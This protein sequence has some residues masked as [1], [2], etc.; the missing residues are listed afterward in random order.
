MSNAEDILAEAGALK[1]N[2]HYV[3]SSGRHGSAYIDKKA[4]INNPAFLSKLAFEIARRFTMDDIG[5]VIGP[6]TGGAIMS[7]HVAHHLSR[8]TCLSV[9]YAT[10]RKTLKGGIELEGD[11]LRK[12]HHRRALIVDDILTTGE[13]LRKTIKASTQIGCHIVGACV[14]VNRGGV[15][16]SRIEGDTG[17]KNLY[18]DALVSMNLES[19]LAEDCALCAQGVPINTDLGHGTAPK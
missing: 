1:T 19:W 18:L 7:A 16:A 5:V 10:A 3:Y 9:N 15:T 8:L 17:V 6:E 12:A 13:S 4:A 14:L 11:D 2:G